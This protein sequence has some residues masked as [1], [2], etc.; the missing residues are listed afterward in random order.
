MR[1]V[2]RRS[3]VLPSLAGALALVVVTAGAATAV[4][5]DTVAGF[6]RALWWSLSLMTTVGFIGD[7]PQTAAGA[8]LSV[9]LMVAGFFLLGLV[10]AALA[11]VFVREEQQPYE[12]RDEATLSL[13]LAEVGRLHAR[14]DALGAPASPD[15]RAE[16]V[17]PA[18]AS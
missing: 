13:L 2:I 14:L 1:V 17:V 16:P 3:W 10:S 12:D 11:S 5:T 8:A 6:P 9:V 18:R 15:A 4:E 7:P